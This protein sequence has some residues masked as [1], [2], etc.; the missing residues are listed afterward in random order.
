MEF[1]RQNG[2]IS[3]LGIA[4]ETSK[5][6]THKAKQSW[7]TVNRPSRHVLESGE[8]WWAP[9]DDASQRETLPS[10]GVTSQQ[11]GIEE[12]MAPTLQCATK[13]AV[14]TTEQHQS[15]QRSDSLKILGAGNI[16]GDT[17]DDSLLGGTIPGGARGFYGSALALGINTTAATPGALAATTTTTTTTPTTT[18]TT[19]AQQLRLQEAGES[20]EEKSEDKRCG[21]AESAL[22]AWKGEGANLIRLHEQSRTALF[23]PFRVAQAPRGRDLHSVRVTQGTF[24]E[25]G[26]EFTITDNWRN[27]YRA[28]LELSGPWV[29]ETTFFRNSF[30]LQAQ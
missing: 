18:T 8:P 22:D 19:T 3:Y 21:S 24:L 9:P 11:L 25:S 28:H 23:T 10:G 14:R 13:S 4:K 15:D 12:G 16:G 29:G 2:L 5:P 30:E 6:E 20:K 7:T 1:L 26:K 17:H 27:S